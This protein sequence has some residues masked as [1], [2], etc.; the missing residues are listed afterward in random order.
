M[1]PPVEGILD[2]VAHRYR[3]ER[4]VPLGDIEFVD[5]KNRAG[6][7]YIDP[8][9]APV[10]TGRIH[11]THGMRAKNRKH[12]VPKVRTVEDKLE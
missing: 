6:M 12:R 1:A 11:D 10:V 8:K 5:G 4:L 3:I 2:F 9:R 7:A